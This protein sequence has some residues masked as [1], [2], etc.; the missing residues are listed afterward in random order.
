MA[1]LIT[2]K[3]LS[4]SLQINISGFALEVHGDVYDWWAFL[5]LQNRN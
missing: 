5:R 2:V 4:F 3:P 1:D